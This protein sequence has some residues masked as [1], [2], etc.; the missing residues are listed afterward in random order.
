LLYEHGGEN[1]SHV[2]LTDGFVKGMKRKKKNS[3]VLSL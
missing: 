3:E 2:G 1:G